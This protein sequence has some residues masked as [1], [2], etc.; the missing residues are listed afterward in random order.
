[1]ISSAVSASSDRTVANSNVNN[2]NNEQQRG[3]LATS[4]RYRAKEVL[5]SA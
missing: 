3:I 1:M 5:G 4:D 2:S